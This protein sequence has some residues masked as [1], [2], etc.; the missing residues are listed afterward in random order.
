MLSEILDDC[1]FGDAMAKGD[2]AELL[3]KPLPGGI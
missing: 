2:A 3:P 1:G